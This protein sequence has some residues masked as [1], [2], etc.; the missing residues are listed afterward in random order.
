[1]E[2]EVGGIGLAAIV[3]LCCYFGGCRTAVV[4]FRLRE[5]IGPQA[6]VAGNAQAELNARAVRLL[7]CTFLS[8]S[9]LAAVRSRL[10][11]RSVVNWFRITWVSDSEV[12]Y[13]FPPP[14]MMTCTS[15]TRPMI[16]QYLDF[17]S[18]ALHMTATPFLYSLL[19]E[20]L[21]RF[22]AIVHLALRIQHHRLIQMWCR[23]SLHLVDLNIQ[24][25]LAFSCLATASMIR[26]LET[27]VI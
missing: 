3:D 19:E 15:R 2:A 26:C 13:S 25:I 16:H 10:R 8:S 6:I 5:K 12:S 4:G 11:L 9:T 27:D 17:I 21:L 23:P 20:S 24:T 1:M 22:L 18:G 14:P 7:S